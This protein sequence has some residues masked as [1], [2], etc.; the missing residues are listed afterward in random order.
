MNNRKILA[1]FTG[2]NLLMGV[3][4]YAVFLHDPPMSVTSSSFIVNLI[5]AISLYYI[6]YVL[7]RKSKELDKGSKDITE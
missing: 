4:F 7:Y 1:V 3:L 5:I 2:A 6:S